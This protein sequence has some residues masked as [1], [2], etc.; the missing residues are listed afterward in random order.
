MG[1]LEFRL[2]FRLEMR[3]R[4]YVTESSETLSLKENSEED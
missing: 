2:E 1:R 3:H 4:R